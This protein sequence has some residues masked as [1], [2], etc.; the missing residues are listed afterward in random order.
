MTGVNSLFWQAFRRQETDNSILRFQNM[1]NN[2]GKAHS[3]LESIR[4]GVR[5]DV[6]D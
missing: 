1:Q 5:C 3:Q 4:A 2:T 6:V